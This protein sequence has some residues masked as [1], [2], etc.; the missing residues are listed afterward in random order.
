MKSR[1]SWSSGEKTNKLPID[2][3]SR[4]S[5]N[6]QP[7]SI[8]EFSKENIHNVALLCA[9]KILHVFMKK[10]PR[11]IQILRSHNV[12]INFLLSY[13]E[14]VQGYVGDNLK[15]DEVYIS[16]LITESEKIIEKMSNIYEE[17]SIFLHSSF[18]S[19]LLPKLGPLTFPC[20]LVKIESRDS[21]YK[22]ELFNKVHCNFSPSSKEEHRLSDLKLKLVKDHILE[23][24]KLK[25][26]N[27]SAY[28]GRIEDLILSDKIIE[29]FYNKNISR[30]INAE[31]R[32]FFDFLQGN[33]L[34][35]CIVA[36]RKIRK[37]EKFAQFKDEI[38][39]KHLKQIELGI[40]KKIGDIQGRIQEENFTIFIKS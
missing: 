23:E 18:N 33:K 16:P 8:F 12:G 38:F 10:I 31:F 3:E 20:D 15:I 14:V 17:P 27:L 37:S 26:T 13:G 34:N 36:L 24:R 30:F 9:L 6:N 1:S 2:A 4:N 5:I 39:K 22:I 32:T 7:D 28:N 29:F 21:K 25:L 11:T 40:R 19:N 35:E